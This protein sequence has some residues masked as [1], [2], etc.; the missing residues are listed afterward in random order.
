MHSNKTGLNV[1]KTSISI[2]ILLVITTSQFYPQWKKL[3]IGTDADLMD[4]HFVS[5]DKGWVVGRGPTILKTVDGGKSWISQQANIEQDIYSVF[6]V[7]ENCGW[8]G[9]NKG[10]IIKTTDGGRKWNQCNS[11]TV[12]TVESLYFTDKNHGYAVVNRWSNRRGGWI[13]QTMDGGDTWCESFQTNHY[14]LID[15]NF[16]D[17]KNG[18][19]VGSNGFF[20]RTTDGALN[21]NTQK[22]IS[23]YWLHSVFFSDSNFGWAAGGGEDR[24]I[25]LR[26]LNGGKNW[27]TVKNSLQKGFL[28]G[29]YFIN[30]HTGWFCGSDGM[31]FRT[32]DSGNNWWREITNT[33]QH[34]VEMFFFDD[35]GYVVGKNGTV[36]KSMCEPINKTLKLLSPIGNEEWEIG[37][38][39]KISWVSEGIF[40]VR[41][42][43]SYNNGASWNEITACYPSTGIFE[44]TVPNI[45]SNQTRIRIIGLDNTG[46]RSESE[47]TFKIVKE[48]N[49]IGTLERNNISADCLY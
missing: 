17:E 7:N 29:S 41:I 40:D 43:Y 11:G 13:L 24:S 20:I 15:I 2:F 35:I 32:D 6:F 26:T 21:W 12:Y 27:S 33:D 49:I 31:I 10:A 22:T 18:W 47:M 3:P 48:A 37:S 1:M 28:A 16:V 44:W 25:I 4:L 46:L 8:A 5:P 39:K 45:M 14:G 30:D 36:L 23:S 38:V 34:L 42:D 19:A 9:G